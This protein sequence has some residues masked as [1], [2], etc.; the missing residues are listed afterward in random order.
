M[1]TIEP[2]I[3]GLAPIAT[4]DPELDAL[5]ARIEI[6]EDHEASRALASRED[7]GEPLRARLEQLAASVGDVE[8]A[9]AAERSVYEA[10]FAEQGDRYRRIEAIARAAVA[11]LTP[12]T[13]A[14]MLRIFEEHPWS[15][16]RLSVGTALV[17]ASSSRSTF[18]RLARAMELPDPKMIWVRDVGT[19]AAVRLDPPT[20]FDRLE[21]RFELEL[22]QRHSYLARGLFQAVF[23]Y[24]TPVDPR[25]FPF[26]VRFFDHGE[27]VVIQA[28]L[29]AHPVP[30]AVDALAALVGARAAAGQ[31]WLTYVGFTLSAWGPRG[32][33]AA[34]AVVAA[35]AAA[36]EAGWSDFRLIGPLNVLVAMDDPSVLPSL[37]AVEGKAIRKAKTA[38]Q[39]VL[40]KLARNEPEAPKE[41]RPTTSKRSTPTRSADADR[42]ALAT[43]LARAG[44][45]EARVAELTM[46]ARDRIVLTPVKGRPGLGESRFGGE[47]DL[48]RG[49]AW[50]VLRLTRKAAEEQLSQG[51]ASTP[52]TV[53][54]KHVVVPLGFVAQL[55]L[56]AIAPLDR[57]GRLPSAG[58]LSF[59]ARQDVQPG[60]HGEL[61]RVAATVLFHEELD[62]L[63]PVAPPEDVP[64][65]DRY[66]V[67]A[68]RATREV[69]LAPPPHAYA[70]GLLTEES[71][72]YDDLYG[73]AMGSSPFGALGYARAAYYRGLPAR[74]ETL[75]LQ[76]ASGS[77]TGFQWGDAS[78]IFFLI[79]DA[80]LARRDFAKVLCVS[81][82]C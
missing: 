43:A 16:A 66:P 26:F 71:S 29:Q 79:A 48:P 54:G 80:A 15:G 70:L 11:H 30:A 1:N 60:E 25:W 67:R 41:K 73:K 69:P 57:E 65:I 61:Y 55:R 8:A 17:A 35:V 27:A 50:P 6:G 3:R 38:F 44:F 7:A 45:S 21:P 39:E 75:L 9:A 34:P 76:L 28:V 13:E 22:A 18:G 32:S 37:R 78:S 64:K 53:E 42:E 52:H 40:K 23:T 12:A 46:L 31:P 4:G 81:D 62:A 56:E 36:L 49:T 82:E 72:S 47:P 74:G 33:V 59:F 58:L 5:V 20:A 51:L 24:A 14:A 63:A 19:A 68:V 77:S 10:V 2:F